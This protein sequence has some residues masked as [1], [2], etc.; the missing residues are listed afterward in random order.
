MRIRKEDK[1]LWIENKVIEGINMGRSKSDSKHMAEEMWEVMMEEEDI[2]DIT[3]NDEF[4]CVRC[5][6]IFDIEESIK[7]GSKHGDLYCPDCAK[8]T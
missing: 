8:N 5:H 3:V 4:K 6:G 2:G 1:Q 7:V